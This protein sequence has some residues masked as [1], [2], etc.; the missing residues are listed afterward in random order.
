MFLL[1]A[2]RIV[3]I[4][5]FVICGIAVVLIVAIYFL[6]PV[7]KRKQFA[8]ARKNLSRREQLFKQNQ[9][10]EKA[11]EISVDDANKVEAID[12]QES[13]EAV[14]D[15]SLSGEIVFPEVKTMAEEVNSSFTLTPT[16]D[17][18]EPLASEA[19]AKESLDEVKEEDEKAPAEE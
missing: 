1:E 7:F 2:F 3:D 17:N 10:T 11:E 5:F 12:A 6:I 9:K 19:D 14:E 8:E 16:L 4:W 18:L 15:A 13:D